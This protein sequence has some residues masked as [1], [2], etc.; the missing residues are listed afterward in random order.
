MK[1][2]L[3]ILSI[4]FGSLLVLVL[5]AGWLFTS[6]PGEN[7][8]R[9]WL[10]NR[11][12]TE[13]GL[14]VS[15]EK[16]ET[17]LWSRV[18][19]DTLTINM[20]A[21]PE[22]D[23]VLYV[24]QIRIGYSIFQLLGKAVILKS[25]TIDSVALAVERDSL[26][27]FGIPLLDNPPTVPA[28]TAQGTGVIGI[29]SVSF[30]RM[31]LSYTDRKLPL[32]VVLTGA[33][34]SARGSR[35][36]AFSGRLTVDSIRADY[37][38]LPLMFDHLETAA[39]FDR[40]T[41]HLEQAGV[42][43]GG[44]RL[45]AS[46]DLGIG[47]TNNVALT[48]SVNGSPG[49]LVAAM[50][51]GFDSLS[52]EVDH[53]NAHGRING[54]FNDP[55]VQLDVSLAD[56]AVQKVAIPSV[57]LLAEYRNDHILVDTFQASGLGG[58]I[59]GRGDVRLDAEGLS[60]L[61]LRLDRIDPAAVWR[62]VYSETSPFK[63]TLGGRIEAAGRGRELASWTVNAAVSGKD[64][65]YLDRSV[66]PLECTVKL[67]S[68]RT[69]LAL[70]HGSDEIRA[71]IMFGEDSLRG[72]F[73]V[74]V[75]DI[76]ALSRFIDQPDLSG[77]LLARGTVEG[78]Y[79]NPTVQ[80]TV[81]GTGITF[82]GFPADSLFADLSYRD[83]S[84]TVI[85][86]IC[87]GG[88]DSI[89]SHHPPFDIDSIFGSLTYDCR[90]RGSMSNLTGGFSAVME[91]PRYGSYAADFLSLDAALEGTQLRITK[92]KAGRG[93]LGI[94]MSGAYDLTASTGS[95]D[96]WCHSMSARSDSGASTAQDTIVA[97]NDFGSVSGEFTL[98]SH[99]DLSATVH[100]RKLWLGL[101]SM[102][103]DDTTVS[104]GELNFDL[105]LNGPYLSPAAV[106]EATARS[107]ELSDYK[108][109]S[110]SARLRVADDALIVDSLVSY[111]LGQSL[112]GAGRL[113]LSISP[114]GLFEI[115]DKAGI[116][117]ELSTMNFDLSVLENLFLPEG[118]L[119]G[120]VATSMDVRG[121]LVAPRF[122]GW[123]TAESGRILLVN[124]STPV[125]NIMLSL[126]FA[127]SVLTIDSATG[128]VTNIPIRASGSLAA[129]D[130]KSASV[131]L[132]VIVGRL[133]K[134]VI[135]GT[136]SDT[137]VHLQVLSDS[138]NLA[139]FQPFVPMLDSLAGRLGCR[140]LIAGQPAAP[141]IDGSVRIDALGLQLP[142]HHVVVSD[143]RADIRF[144]QGR[145]ILDSALA[146]LNG[147]QVAVSGTIAHDKGE[148]LDIGLTLQ[149]YKITLQEPGTY[150]VAV[151]SAV[152]S[153]GRR[154]ENYV[155]DGDI[156][157]GEARLT[158]GL[159]PTS[160]LPWVKS[161][162]TVDFEFPELIARSRLDVRIRE[163]NELWV[164]NNLARIRLRAE[165]GVIGTP[166]RPNFT[167]ML[168]VEEG[169]LLYLDR[170]FRVN[171][172]TVYFNDPAR[173]NPDINL[174]A[175]TE[176][177]IYR[178]TAAEP[179]TVYIKAEGLLDQLQYGL[180]S[181]PPLEKSDIVALLTLGA[182]RTDLAGGEGNGKGGLK[183]VLKDRAAMLT[184]ERVSSYL[185][186]RVGSLF[187][188]NEFTI[189]GNLFQ[190]DNSWGPQLV[191]SKRLSRKVDF[192]YSTT[193]GHLNDQTVRLGYRLTP[194]FSLQ[195]ETDRQGRAGLD[196]KYGI[197]FK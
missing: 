41:F 178:R 20:A 150:I 119:G 142:R 21:G 26:G 176:I 58:T 135:G 117:A 123:L 88:L 45:E 196:L 91:N 33:T 145:V 157:L 190:F 74:S 115:K 64:L 67:E 164:D 93:D 54:T 55:V 149:A 161:M 39:S 19:I 42:N 154:Q 124:G 108:I 113:Q 65:R 90:L 23:P 11:I 148:L 73:D 76:T 17:N 131:D 175:S 147:G 34:L 106:L 49:A 36:G 153:Y 112:C 186:R 191:A 151:D 87:R 187:G 83:S 195:G 47:D 60:S 72:T 62:V 85:D 184:S 14:P 185:S 102:I 40:E 94:L 77:R 166:L 182:T 66:P 84:L 163:S 162:E 92:L 69:G 188:F 121:T 7:L 128:T 5:L 173:F 43:C 129:S 52:L 169:Y 61:S 141:Q 179:Y 46:G 174:D 6:T 3:K 152:L 181:E 63:G 122:N 143:G 160:I 134:A 78:I 24:G 138:L 158:A 32:S 167:G 146:S 101:I 9:G 50:T 177:T 8:I 16:F 71:D 192:T 111:A 2:P 15:I 98:G 159:R 31:G 168:Q 126:M 139:V 172:G 27:R 120:L 104:D 53:I 116:E 29:D 133:G 57:R 107:I 10:E 4:G 194:R 189:Q 75:P 79:S 136:V 44:L 68:G 193:V 89:D 171:E 155:L 110:I 70:V 96:L 59:A 81:D 80:A 13:I 18:R 156:V 109:D 86:F 127:D 165:L 140:V 12:T 103:T 130:F 38:G 51:A 1:K 37:D 144:D 125:E 97:R 105:D 100:G 132:D 35:E 137:N 180:Y 197:T 56:M 82:R 30:T 95:F 99:S 28:D 48:V 25:L 118:K 170:R 22:T 114:D 183:G